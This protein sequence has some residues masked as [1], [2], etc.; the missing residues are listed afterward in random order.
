MLSVWDSGRSKAQ[1]ANNGTVD[2]GDPLSRTRFRRITV[3]LSAPVFAELQQYAKFN[4]QA[5]A[6]NYLYE[7][8]W[9]LSEA[10]WSVSLTC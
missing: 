2:A 6:A 7:V 8:Y 4:F 10:T 1:M 3:A 5:Q 9:L